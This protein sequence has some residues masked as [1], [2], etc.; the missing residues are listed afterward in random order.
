MKPIDTNL[1]FRTGSGRAEVQVSM[2]SKIS[3]GSAEKCPRPKLEVRVT[4][5]DRTTHS[6]TTTLR[7]SCATYKS[8]K[9]TK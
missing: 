2:E 4:Q 6:C 8:T 1:R 7:E 9:L 3:G 5:C